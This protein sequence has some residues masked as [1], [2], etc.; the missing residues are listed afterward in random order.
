MDSDIRALQT[1]PEDEP[2]IGLYPC[3]CSNIF[4]LASPAEG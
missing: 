2:E 1:L 3:T 4:S